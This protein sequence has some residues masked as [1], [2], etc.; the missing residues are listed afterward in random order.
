MVLN[1][2]LQRNDFFLKLII[3]NQYVNILII[4]FYIFFYFK[5][6]Y[7]RYEYPRVHIL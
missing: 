1:D 6:V 2:S 7:N 5:L 3:Q 4:Y